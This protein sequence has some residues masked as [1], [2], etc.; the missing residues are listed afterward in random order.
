[1]NLSNKDSSIQGVDYCHITNGIS[2]FEAAN[3]LK[4]TDL[5]EKSGTLWNMKIYY[6]V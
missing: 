1:M 4:N 6:H 2:K 5:S 3:L